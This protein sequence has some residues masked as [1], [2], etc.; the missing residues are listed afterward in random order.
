M[1]VPRRRVRVMRI[2]LQ[3]PLRGSERRETRGLARPPGGLLGRRP[4][5]SCAFPAIGGRASGVHPGFFR[6]FVADEL[7]GPPGGAGDSPR[8]IAL[9]L[10]LHVAVRSRPHDHDGTSHNCIHDCQERSRTS[11]ASNPRHPMRNSSNVVRDR[12][13]YG[14]RE[15]SRP[16]DVLGRSALSRFR[17]LERS[18]A[19]PHARC[20]RGRPVDVGLC[21]HDYLFM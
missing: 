18:R 12:R 19:L 14:L 21:S 4:L 10:R 6:P 5:E 16:L 20:T 8:G 3:A 17:R 15:L 1:V 9:L 7:R 11:A 13:F 2:V